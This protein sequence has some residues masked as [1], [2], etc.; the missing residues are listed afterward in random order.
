MNRQ[1][2]IMYIMKLFFSTP[3]NKRPCHRPYLWILLI[4][5]FS[6]PL[7]ALN[8]HKQIFEYTIE[9]RDESGGYPA[10][11]AAGLLQSKE[12]YL[13]ASPGNKLIRY[14]GLDFEIVNLPG[15]SGSDYFISSIFLERDGTFW[16][17]TPRGYFRFQNGRFIHV[18]RESSAWRMLTGPL[19]SASV[20]PAGRRLIFPRSKNVLLPPGSDFN[21]NLPPAGSCSAANGGSWF[22]F[23]PAALVRRNNRGEV[24]HINLKEFAERITLSSLLED[25]EGL[26]WIGSKQGLHL[27]ENPLNGGSRRVKKITVEPVTSIIQDRDGTIWAGT[28][29]GLNRILRSPGHNF[30][31]EKLLPD[32]YIYTL[33]E[34]REGNLWV[35]TRSSGLICLKET[36]FTNYLDPASGSSNPLVMICQDGREGIWTGSPAGALYQVQPGVGIRLL[37]IRSFAD[38]YPFSLVTN[39][40][41]DFLE[42]SNLK[43]YRQGEITFLLNRKGVY[44]GEL[45]SLLVDSRHRTWYAR[46]KEG[47][48]CRDGDRIVTY[49]SQEDFSRSKMI[50]TMLEDRQKNIWIGFNRGLHVLYGGDLNKRKT[51][52]PDVPVSC[53]HED[54]EG[55]LW[56][57]SF[58][59]GVA[60]F[61]PRTEEIFFYN[62]SNGLTDNCIFKILED[63][64]NRLWMTGL[65]G[66]YVAAKNKIGLLREKK[67]DELVSVT[68]DTADGMGSPVCSSHILHSALKTDDGRFLICTKNGLSVTRP[69]RFSSDL[70]IPE[71]FIDRISADGEDL[72][73]YSADSRNFTLKKVKNLTFLLKSITFRGPEKI[74]YR[75][76]LEEIDKQWKESRG[77]QSEIKYSSLSPGIYRLR[78]RTSNS[79]GVW[80]GTEKSFKFKIKSPPVFSP[81]LGAAVLLLMTAAGVLL[82]KLNFIKKKKSKYARTKLDEKTVEEYV[83]KIIYILEKDKIYRDPDLSLKTLSHKLSIPA[84]LISQVINVKTGKNFFDLINGYRIEDAKSRLTNPRTRDQ[85][86]LKIAHDAGFNNLSAFN[87]VFKKFTRMTP[88]EFKNNKSFPTL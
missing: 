77:S 13:W 32:R 64:R 24:Q 66:V 27:M 44:Q 60:R 14:D 42:N 22:F 35:G 51:L 38:F 59:K 68:L 10:S 65:K 69:D 29:S 87:R 86:I 72:D 61:D 63:D 31:I 70:P 57:G 78:V 50:F 26:L 17:E 20:I 71:L 58:Q 45:T 54:Q 76:K 62:R 39:G 52:L 34:D 6:L 40:N 19:I 46:L 25:D 84:Y 74:K 4:I 9:H 33:Y 8:P 21:Q 75:Y 12:G 56:I 2:K 16:A 28:Q 81:L 37:K 83:D 53:L 5:L 15:S 47:L 48:F 80:D 3:A 23:P 85:K 7:R 30:S 43:T 73:I 1:L 41:I 88:T 67:I 11:G 55:I 49:L 36:A 18:P 82:Y 79:F